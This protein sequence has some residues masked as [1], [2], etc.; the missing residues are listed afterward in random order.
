[1]MDWKI[2]NKD[3]GPKML[4][5]STV[6]GQNSA[7]DADV[8][9]AKG[10]IMM[11]VAMKSKGHDSTYSWWKDVCAYGVNICDAIFDHDTIQGN[12]ANSKIADQRMMTGGSTWGG[13]NAG[14]PSYVCPA[15]YNLC[16]DFVSAYGGGTHTT[17][18]N[19]VLTTGFAFLSDTVSDNGLTSNWG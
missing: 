1:M 16:R 5:D 13:F 3:G 8:D 7:E 2:A 4:S 15:T 10:I 12:S 18:W 14:N 11:C 19:T 17:E 6:W 9:A